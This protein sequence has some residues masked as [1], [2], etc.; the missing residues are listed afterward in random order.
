MNDTEV[1]AL[2]TDCRPKL[3]KNDKLVLQIWLVNN[4]VVPGLTKMLI[5]EH[6]ALGKIRFCHTIPWN[7]CDWF[8]SAGG[9]IDSGSAASHF[10]S[11]C[12]MWFRMCCNLKTAPNIGELS[13][14]WAIGPLLEWIVPVFPMARRSR[15]VPPPDLWALCTLSRL[16]ARPLHRANCL[17]FK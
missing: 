11:I 13:L 14:V 7:T 5:Q 15:C 17:A 10:W 12:F 16:Q 3:H 1:Q 6:V 9:C 8:R 2:N 4:N